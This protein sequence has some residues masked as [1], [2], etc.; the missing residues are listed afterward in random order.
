[1]LDIIDTK[2]LVYSNLYQ[3]CASIGPH[4]HNCA[5]LCENVCTPSN[6]ECNII[7]KSIPCCHH[8]IEEYAYTRANGCQGRVDWHFNL[9]K[10]HNL[11]DGISKVGSP[12]VLAY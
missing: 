4:L 1:M 10:T 12:C 5:M 8:K 3:F 2:N 6:K 11:V 9:P 7:L